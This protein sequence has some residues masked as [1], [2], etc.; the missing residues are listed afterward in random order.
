[1]ASHS[2]ILKSYENIPSGTTL[3]CVVPF[4]A[5]TAR[6]EALERLEFYKLDREIPGTVGFLLVD[7][8]SED[9]EARLARDFCAREGWGYARLDTSARIFSVGRCR[10]YGAMLANSP[11]VFMQDVDLM[12]WNGFYEKLLEEIEIQELRKDARA[13]LM[14]PYIFLTQT[15]SM[16]FL[17]CE[18]RIRASRFQHAALVADESLAEKISTGTSANVYNRLWYLS[19]GGNR[20]AFEGWGYE[21]L[22]FN[23]RL[24]KQWGLFPEPEDWTHEQYNFNSV[25]KYRTWKAP[26][27]LLGDLLFQKGLVL[28]HAWHPV[29]EDSEY[30]LRADANRAVFLKCLTDFKN[31]GSEP[32]PLP[33]LHAGRTLLMR[34]NAFTCARDIQ[35]R[36]GEILEPE[37]ALLE[38]TTT[39]SEFANR[40]RIDRVVFHNPYASEAMLRL[41]REARAENIPYLVA[42]RGALPGSCFFDSTGF[43]SDGDS[44]KAS[45]W[46]VPL[47]DELRARVEAYIECMR[48]DSTALEDQS[49][50]VGAAVLRRQLGLH[51][52][53][54]V[55]FLCLQRPGD[56]VTRHFCGTMESYSAY[57]CMMQEVALRLPEGWQLVVKKHPLEDEVIALS[58]AVQANDAHVHDLLEL[59][60]AVATFNSGVG[61]LALVWNKP[62]V[63]SGEAYYAHPDLNSTI[64][65]TDA[66]IEWLI[67]PRPPSLEKATR[68][69]AYLLCNFYSFGEFTT[70]PVRMPDGSRMTATTDIRF[71]SIQGLDNKTVVWRSKTPAR[72]SWDSPLFDRYKSWKETKGKILNLFSLKSAK[73][74][75]FPLMALLKIL[76]HRD[77]ASPPIP[78]KKLHGT[79]KERLRR[80][81]AS[82]VKEWMLQRKL[83]RKWLEQPR[84]PQ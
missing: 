72:I 20:E 69:L 45:R 30:R 35:P 37:A 19:R 73:R 75:R 74:N 82:P 8:G 49:D 80:L 22:E 23:A 76:E 21:D 33:D 40:E 12:P 62:V 26:Y 24:L 68:F 5:S 71:F 78:S 46:D 9:S 60:D 53:C 55:L 13:F 17:R 81:L 57:L 10:N 48:S 52:G 43:L 29:Y 6:K 16:E 61:V 83:R 79:V 28:F 32:E 59:A 18:S 1:M 66:L 2:E 58:G 54:K 34:K 27:R 15:G 63:V 14:V 42:E 25:V 41:Y 4:R 64:T 56:A 38:G 50:R 11:F 44:Y 39:L 84:N 70:R 67:T 77:V 3:T 7:D 51:A 47:N 36:W 65:S 31:K